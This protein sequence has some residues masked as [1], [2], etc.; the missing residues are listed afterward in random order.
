MLCLMWQDNLLRHRP[1]SAGGGRIEG[2]TIARNKLDGL[3]VRDGADPVV[4]GN[5]VLQ[6][7]GAGAS[8]KVML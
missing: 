3:L 1:S 4:A 5:D 6:N 7:G 8:L 2:C